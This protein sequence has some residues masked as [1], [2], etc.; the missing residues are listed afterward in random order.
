MNFE[1]SDLRESTEFL[2]TLL[3]NI[4]SAIFILDKK[5]RVHDF[6]DS[7]MNLFRNEEKELIGQLCGNAI[8]CYYQV[9][10]GKDCGQ[11]PH[12]GNCT[13]RASL[14]E[15]LTKKVPSTKQMLV[16]EF[17]LQDKKIKKYFQYTTRYIQYASEEMIL[18]I[19]DDISELEEKNQALVE[20]N[21]KKNQLMGIA[22]HDLRN[23]IGI[24]QMYSSFILQELSGNLLKEQKDFIQTIYESSQFMLHLLDDLLDFSTIESGK[25]EL[26]LHEG[27]YSRIVKENVALNKVFADKK[28][29]S[30][31]M[32]GDFQSIPL[33]VDHSKVEQVLNNLLSN[34]IKYSFSGT[35]IVVRVSLDEKFVRTEVID[36]GQGI[37]TGELEK[38]FSPFVKTSVKTTAGEKS[39]G[40]GLAIVKKIVEGHGGN[41]GVTSEVGKGSNF[42]FTLPREL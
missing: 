5:I 36:Q 27:D 22:A 28:N 37:P 30:I 23:P 18:I 9:E 16:R 24:V 42:Y 13:L 26:E 14:L 40:L 19:L 31:T 21:Q 20:L 8:G 34:A 6:N 1:L 38:V 7:F 4:N 32:E 35:A 10:T 15:A 41:I 11:T 3:S 17:Y 2:N 29:I 39:T 12:C 25:L 33:H